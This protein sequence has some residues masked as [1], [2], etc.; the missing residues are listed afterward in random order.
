[1]FDML[2]HA[3][4]HKTAEAIAES[5]LAKEIGNSIGSAL[6]SGVEAVGKTVQAAGRVAERGYNATKVGV[7]EAI[8]NYNRSK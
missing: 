6:N 8:K 2:I 7:K 1:M 3:A 5:K 4:I